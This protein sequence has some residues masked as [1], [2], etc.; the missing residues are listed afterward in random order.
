MRGACGCSSVEN[1]TPVMKFNFAVYKG[2]PTLNDMLDVE[3][4]SVHPG[5]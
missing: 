3:D 1:T 2:I 5:A 4:P